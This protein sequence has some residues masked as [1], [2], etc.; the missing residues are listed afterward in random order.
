MVIEPRTGAIKMVSFSA[1]SREDLARAIE[2]RA[3]RLLTDDIAQILIESVNLT[4]ASRAGPDLEIRRIS[5]KGLEGGGRWPSSPP[6]EEIGW[7]ARLRL[8]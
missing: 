4:D 5:I 3:P 2:L 8:R 7:F 6:I 1:T